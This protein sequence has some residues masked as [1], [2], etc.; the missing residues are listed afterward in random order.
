MVVIGIGNL[1]GGVGSTTLTFQ[2]A[3]LLQR[4][5]MTVTIAETSSCLSDLHWCLGRAG[6]EGT[7]LNCSKDSVA[8]VHL[9]DCP[10]WLKD[11]QLGTEFVLLD[12]S[13]GTHQDIVTAMFHVHHWICPL[14]VSDLHP[15]IK[16][17]ECWRSTQPGLPG[18][19]KTFSAV[20][21]M[22]P[23]A[24]D[25]ARD[26]GFAAPFADGTHAITVLN[27]K[28]PGMHILQSRLTWSEAVSNTF[29]GADILSQATP[30][31]LV[32]RSEIEMIWQEA[33]LRMKWGSFASAARSK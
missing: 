18:A 22:V 12:Y 13:N 7:V 21:T 26:P 27:Q 32:A 33:L 30:E 25:I 11:Y 6:R 19:G 28:V 1:K 14:Q 5:G 15:T 4:N 8:Y 2:M 31:S 20:F 10:N 9:K 29:G 17:Y 23:D 16:S 3:A 24:H